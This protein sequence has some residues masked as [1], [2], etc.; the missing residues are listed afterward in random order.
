MNKKVSLRF[1]IDTG[2]TFTDLV[3]LDEDTGQF[4]MN[5]SPTTPQNTLIGVLNVIGKANL[6]LANVKRFFIHGSTTAMN[7]IIEQKGAKTAYVATKGFRD[8]PEIARYNRPE[9]YNPKYHK[10]QQIVPR[11]LRF[12]VSERLNARGEVLVSLDLEDVRKLANILKKKKIEAVA[13]CLLH[14]YKNPLHERKVKEIILEEYPEISV[15][16]SSDIVTEHREYERSMT[17]I[18]TAYLSLIVEAWTGE[19]EKALT[20]Q[21]FKG[22]IVLTRSDGG[23]MTIEA[24]KLSPMNTIL[25]GPA[26][27][28]IGA[29][30]IADRFEKPNLITM[31][32]GGTSFDVCMIK[33]R[34]ARIEQDAKISGHSI[35]IPNLD[36]RTVGA[37]GGS[38]A[39]IDEAGALHVGPK[40]AGANPGPICYAQ[41]GTEPT[42]TDAALSNGYIDP[43]YFLGGE[44]PL[45]T[46]IAING[47]ISIICK[48]L[49]MDINAASSGILRIALSNMAEAI[50]D[51]AAE[52]GDDVREFSLLCFGGGGP[53]FGSYLM[54]ELE[55]PSA[56]VPVAPANFCAWGMMMVDIRHDFSST[57]FKRL[58]L[59]SIDEL[60]S[61]FNEL[62]NKGMNI[63]T[64]EGVASKDMKFVKSLD[65][66][67]IGQEHT[68]SVQINFSINGNS[69]DMIYEEFTKVYKEIYGYSL[70]QMAEVV[71][72]RISA[73]GKITN[74]TL[75]NIEV[76]MRKAD[77]AL[78][79]RRKVFDFMEGDW[80]FHNVYERSKLQANNMIVG[81]AL[82]EEPTSVTVVGERHQAEVDSIGN[83]IITRK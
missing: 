47:I 80:I 28:V 56:I 68:V 25:S 31:D 16:I 53:L 63:L 74:P 9:M 42:I 41:G 3:V 82:I 26:G 7:A 76:G 46:E 83:L 21:G 62:I 22:Q 44:M 18:L 2:G 13:V 57:L 38:I 59:V 40:S 48:P 51:I 58:N 30:Y 64:D 1:S 4:T 39:W 45:D 60:Y 32:M 35:L 43:E 19:L 69:K 5:K 52:K 37:G 81:P 24:S 20:R 29:L 34:N 66:R 79:D 36:I 27:G 70:E 49:N 17:T 11:E 54:D 8:V 10:P 23:G 12:E 15:A 78:K 14:S 6:D 72:L 50:K 55:I 33:D 75:K 77:I 67:Y 71:N 61:K 73:I 65:M